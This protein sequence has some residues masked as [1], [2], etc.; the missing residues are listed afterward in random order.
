MDGN[1]PDPGRFGFVDVFLTTKHAQAAVVLELVDIT[2]DSMI[3][4]IGRCGNCIDVRP[5]EFGDWM[6]KHS[7]ATLCKMLSSC[8]ENEDSFVMNTVGSAR[9]SA[10]ERL[11]GYVKVI[12]MG[13]PKVVSD[14]G[15]LDVRVGVEPGSDTLYSLSLVS[16][17][18]RRVL[19]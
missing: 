7:E 14:S 2:A 16:V 1:K 6:A 19:W 17:A 11:G 13:V 3:Y 5:M 8:Y 4:A 9:Q 15:V 12:G 10:M 18:G